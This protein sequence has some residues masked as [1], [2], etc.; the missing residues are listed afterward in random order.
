M[1]TERDIWLSAHLMIQRHGEAAGFEAAL[2]ADQFLERGDMAGRAV[3]LRIVKAI[4][5]LQATRPAPGE[6]PQ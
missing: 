5:A 4:E 1:P 3:W 2:K 6:R